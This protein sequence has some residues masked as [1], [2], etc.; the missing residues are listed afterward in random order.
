MKLK[1][2]YILLIA[3]FL[4][5]A[6]SND[7]DPELN[8][9]KAHLSIAVSATSI[10]SRA[11]TSD[12]VQLPGEAN[13]NSLT[14]L[15]FDETGARIGYKWQSTE[16][17][18]GES[19]IEDVEA[20]PV[21]ARIALV[22]NASEA[23]FSGVTTYSSFQAALTSLSAQSQGSLVMSSM[24]INP[25]VSLSAGENNIGFGSEASLPGLGNVILLTRVPARV[26]IGNIKTD[27]TG[28]P[29]EG[30][31]V[32]IDAIYLTSVNTSSHYY[33]PQDWGVVEDTGSA[34][35][36]TSEATFGEAIDDATPFTGRLTSYYVLENSGATAPTTLNVRATLLAKGDSPAQT[37][38]FTQLVNPN[39]LQN[40]YTHN[41][42]K[43]NYVYRLNI[44]FSRNSFDNDDAYLNVQVQV[45]NWGVVRQGPVID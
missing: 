33:S 7:D 34:R 10:L 45:A 27:F 11:E 29:L 41:F 21:K 18:E 16:G 35:R 15:V 2:I 31:S 42:I 32:R 38:L 20:E 44:T 22:A 23:A 36:I 17:D 26:D 37:K 8:D 19:R 43:R 12:I 25:S 9:G 6:C 3:P 40:G 30:R 39:G 1:K 24:E 14:A 5:A 13:I 4:L 28:S